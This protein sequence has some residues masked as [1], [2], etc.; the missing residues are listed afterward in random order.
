LS[1]TLYHIGDKLD[2]VYFPLTGIISLL[3]WMEDGS[4]GEIAIVGREG[5][6]DTAVYIDRRTPMCSAI[7]QAG[8]RAITLPAAVAREEFNR[9]GRFRDL[10]LHYS[11]ALTTQIAYTALCNR[12]HSIE[13]QLAR[14]LLLTLD[15]S[16][17]FDLRMTQGL[18]ASMLG[19]RREGV[20]VAAGRLQSRG[21]ISYS[22]GKIQVTDREALLQASCECYT[23]I[24][25]GYH[26]LDVT[27]KQEPEPK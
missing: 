13:Q 25:N 24:V 11:Q 27:G 26:Q 21:V 19:V 9:N 1:S 6:A 14:W 20:T 22:R 17:R 8:G 5:I 23:A 7:V 10:L 15:R 12:H 2:K 4:T 16:E 18:I 3:L